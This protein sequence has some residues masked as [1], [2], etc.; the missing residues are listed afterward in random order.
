MQL[1]VCTHVEKLTGCISCCWISLRKRHAPLKEGRRKRSLK[2]V[3]W[4]FCLGWLILATQLFTAIIDYV[5]IAP[6]EAA[7]NIADPGDTSE[8]AGLL[9]LNGRFYLGNGL[10]GGCKRGT[11][12]LS[13]VS[14][15]WKACWVFPKSEGTTVLALSESYWAGRV[16]YIATLPPPHT[17]SF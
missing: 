13:S 14:A 12:S 17:P 6:P 4:A 5:I 10:S 3:L 1:V 7:V 16:L 9:V 2:L 8:I 15:L 11:V